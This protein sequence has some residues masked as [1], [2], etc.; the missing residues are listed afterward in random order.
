M[1]LSKFPHK[2]DDFFDPSKELALKDH[3]CYTMKY[4]HELTDRDC[5][6][7]SETSEE[8]K[9]VMSQLKDLAQDRQMR[10]REEARDKRIRT[11][12]TVRHTAWEEGHK[13][14]IKIGEERGHAKIRKFVL[15]MRKKGFD[16]SLI[17]E[18]TGLSQSEIQKIK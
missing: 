8:M 13:K 1:E 16:E 3:L 12:A 18:L 15:K 9:K 2:I 11:E 6:R 7:L 5:V 14:G 10:F 17:E 4:A